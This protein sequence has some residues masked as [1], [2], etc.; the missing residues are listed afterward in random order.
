MENVR[1]GIGGCVVLWRITKSTNLESLQTNLTKL[2]LGQFCPEARSQ[3]SCLRSALDSVFEPNDGEKISIQPVK[4]G[5]AVVTESRNQDVSAGEDWGTVRAVA[6]IGED[7]EVT[8]DP[9]ND[10]GI[11]AIRAAMESV[12]RWVPAASV[13]KALIKIIEASGGVSLRT[14]GGV[15]WLPQEKIAA[16]EVVANVFT[17]ASAHEDAEGNPAK[18]TAIYALR[19]IADDAMIAAVGDALTAE[20]ELELQRIEQELQESDLQDRAIENR[21]T[22]TSLLLDRVKRFETAFKR[23]LSALTQQI[24]RTTATLSISRMQSVASDILE[25]EQAVASK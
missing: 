20:V 12:A 21:I 13:G 8:L 22:K 17:R 7:G 24:E 25:Q 23:P 11:C 10:A 9:Y 15:Y 19:V 14:E 18:R 3:M 4:G 5:F 6:R 1:L 16:W 2:G